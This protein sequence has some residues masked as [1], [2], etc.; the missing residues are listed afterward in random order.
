MMLTWAE[1]GEEA[2]EREFHIW[3]YNGG[4]TKR[5][6]GGKSMAQYYPVLAVGTFPYEITVNEQGPYIISPINEMVCGELSLRL[7]G[8]NNMSLSEV[9]YEEYENII[10][11]KGD[12][13]S[14]VEWI[15][16][17]QVEKGKYSKDTIRKEYRRFM[18]NIYQSQP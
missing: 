3:A 17:N 2:D 14:L 11:Q 4:K 15:Y 1:E 18:E 12:F 6:I 10:Y 9:P 16:N 13:E 5:Y 7:Q 8:E